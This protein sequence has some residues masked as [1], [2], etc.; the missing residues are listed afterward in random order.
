M[1]AFGCTKTFGDSIKTP[2]QFVQDRCY[3]LAQIPERSNLDWARDLR[4]VLGGDELKYQKYLERRHRVQADARLWKRVMEGTAEATVVVIESQFYIQAIAFGLQKEGADLEHDVSLPEIL[5]EAAL[6]MIDHTPVMRL[7]DF[8][9]RLLPANLYGAETVYRKIGNRFGDAI[10]F[11]ARAHAAF[12][13]DDLDQ[14]GSTNE[15][16]LSPHRRRS[17]SA[18]DTI[19]RVFDSEHPKSVAVLNELFCSSDILLSRSRCE[20]ISESS[21][22]THDALQAADFCAD[23]HRRSC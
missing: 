16:L 20:R 6:C 7:V 23:S 21:S 19:D 13:I 17:I 15:L 4:A 14:A 10:V 2:G 18:V 22:C 3:V 8:A 1:S 11:A 12:D 9:S 5:K